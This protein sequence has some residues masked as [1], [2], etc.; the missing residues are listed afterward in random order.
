MDK[1][2]RELA[3]LL[4]HRSAAVHPGERVM[5]SMRETHTLPLVRAV[6]EACIQAGAQVQ[7]QFL[8]DYLDHSLMAF[9]TPEQVQHVPEIEAYGMEWADVYFGL[10]GA[11]NLYEFAAI[12][13]ETLAQYRQAMGVISDLRWKKTRWVIVRVPNEDM[14]QQAETDVETLMDMFFN[15]CLRDR[16]AETEHWLKVAQVLNQGSLL[17][18]VAHHTDLSFSLEGRTWKVSDGGRNVPGGEILTSPMESTVNGYIGFELPGVLGGRLV[19]GIRLE[20]QNGKLMEATATHNEEFLKR[21]IATD[22]GA[23]RIGEFAIGTNYEVNR[24][25]KDIFYD[26]KIGGTVH[27]ALGRAYPE[28]G[29]TNQSAIHWDL[30]KDT[31]QEGSIYLDGRLIFQNGKILL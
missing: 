17:R 4:V 2:W 3:D 16:S 14:A 7:V 12:P 5:I 28:V 8:S 27:I 30:I 24:F 6:Y 15:A 9:G 19:E 22:V 25:C 29:G 18:L 13:D 21:V 20:W 31:R 26:E 11:H 23:S 1:R 10:R